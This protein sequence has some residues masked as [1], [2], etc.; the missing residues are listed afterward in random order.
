MKLP[1]SKDET[2]NVSSLNEGRN[3]LFFAFMLVAPFY[4]VAGAAFLVD[5]MG[6]GPEFTLMTLGMGMAAW[7]SLTAVHWSNLKSTLAELKLFSAIVRFSHT[8]AY[9]LDMLFDEDQIKYV[10]TTTKKGRDIYQ[11]FF[12]EYFGYN[13]PT[14]GPITFNKA[15]IILPFGNIP[16]KETFSFKN[17]TQ[18]WFK[19]LALTCSNSEFAVFDVS[20]FWDW[21]EGEWIPTFIVADS[22]Q[23]G[24]QANA[25][26][27]KLT[28][29]T[30]KLPT[31]E[32][33][34]TVQKEFTI[35]ATDDPITGNELIQAR[36][37]EAKGIITGLNLKAARLTT[38]NDN[39][40]DDEMNADEMAQQRL[41][42]AKRRHRNIMN[43]KEPISWRTINFKYVGYGLAVLGIILF[44]LYV[45]GA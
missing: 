27:L 33:G 43:M 32:N 35:N 40:M 24:V 37:I 45:L 14:E 2:M 18:V 20:P 3:M 28:E 25:Q 26:M 44:M 1:F 7:G 13:H 4:L 10:G 22:W 38:Q 21:M 30:I 17:K 9:Q 34:Q 42:G 16:W 41:V 39:L 8:V 11:V 29:E 23:H 31:F 6:L 15:F 12:N 5:L 19:G 36:L